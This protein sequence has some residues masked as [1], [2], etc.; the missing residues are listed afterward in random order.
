[1]LGVA[2]RVD[3]EARRDPSRG[4]ASRA[5]SDVTN[6][7]Q[8]SGFCRRTYDGWAQCSVRIDTSSDAGDVGVI[9]HE[10]PE[11]LRERS[12]NRVPC[13]ERPNSPKDKACWAHPPKFWAELRAW[14]KATILKS[15]PQG[16]TRT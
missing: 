12:F 4:A 16:I 11:K 6:L 1:M 5:L 3:L 9:G 14:V 7:V 13:S 15:L 2:V 10:L 8:L